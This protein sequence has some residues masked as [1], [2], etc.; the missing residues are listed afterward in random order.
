MYIIS[1][2]IE[3]RTKEAVRVQEVL[4]KFGNNIIS[5]LGLHNPEPNENDIIIVA[6]NNKSTIEDFRKELEEIKNIRVNI[7]EA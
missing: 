4:T 3:E 1:I 7:M 6:Y 5:R 2:L